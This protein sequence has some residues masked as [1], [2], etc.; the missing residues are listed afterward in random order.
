MHSVTV[1][2][3]SLTTN[4]I[5]YVII[6]AIIIFRYSRP[7]KMNISRLFV[8]PV[9]LLALTAFN[10]YATEITS[11]APP[12][13]IAIAVIAGAVLAIPLGLAMAAHRTV[14]RTEK[15]HVMY[16]DPSWQAAAIWLGAFIV[17]AILR[18]SLPPGANATVLGDGLLVF[19]MATLL[20]Q[21]WAIYQKFRSLDASS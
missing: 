17:K 12:W 18:A 10:I 9:L 5:I 6:G 13:L 3:P 16:V 14:R 20:V 4:V 21:Y 15:P 1:S 11:P 7:M 2:Q 19:G 8:A